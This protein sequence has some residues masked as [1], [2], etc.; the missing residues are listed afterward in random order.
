VKISVSIANLNGSTGF[1]AIGSGAGVT[2][3]AAA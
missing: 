2:I 1:P 3:P